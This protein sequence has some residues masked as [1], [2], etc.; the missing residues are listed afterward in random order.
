MCV[1]IRKGLQV[2]SELDRAAEPK[3]NAFFLHLVYVM[4]RYDYVI[5]IKQGEER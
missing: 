2:V 1:C 4:H 3:L 5:N